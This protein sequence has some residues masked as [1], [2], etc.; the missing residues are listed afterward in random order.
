MDNRHAWGCTHWSW[1]KTSK[2]KRTLCHEHIW[3]VICST[4]QILSFLD[5]HFEKNS[6]PHL[7]MEQRNLLVIYLNV[8]FSNHH[9]RRIL[10]VDLKWRCKF[11]IQK[12]L[13]YESFII[14]Q[15]LPLIISLLLV[16]IWASANY[17]MKF[18]RLG[19]GSFLWWTILRAHWGT[20][21][22]KFLHLKPV[23]V[24]MLLLRFMVA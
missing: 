13:F 16:E 22:L 6:W 23:V 3:E 14:Q 10:Q 1:E 15:M 20:W 7:P 21:K 4:A 9:G 12:W 11:N 18:M 2:A 17:P 8:K 19:K 5:D 24:G